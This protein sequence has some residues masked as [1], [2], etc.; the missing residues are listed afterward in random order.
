VASV[1]A[2]YGGFF[3]NDAEDSSEGEDTTD[4]KNGEKDFSLFLLLVLIEVGKE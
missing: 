3:S 1:C 4:A 2:L